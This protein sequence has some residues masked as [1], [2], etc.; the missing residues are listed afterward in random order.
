[1]DKSVQCPDDD[2]DGPLDKDQKKKIPKKLLS[3][4]VYFQNVLRSLKDLNDRDM[5]T[6]Q[7]CQ[8]I[9]T[10]YT[11]KHKADTQDDKQH[12]PRSTLQEFCYEYFLKTSGTK[13]QALK[14][15]FSLLRSVQ[16]QYQGNRRMTHFARFLSL[17]R[18]E[19]RPLDLTAL[20]YYLEAI[21][22]I[23]NH[24]IGSH[25]PDHDQ[26]SQECRYVSVSRVQDAV[27]KLLSHN[28]DTT[29]DPLTDIMNTL[30]QK[31]TTVRLTT[32]KLKSTEAVP[33]EDALELLLAERE[34][35]TS[36]LA[37]VAVQLFEAA[38]LNHDGVLTF[39]EFKEI[40]LKVDHTQK[41]RNISTL[42]RQA[43]AE[44][45]DDESGAMSPEQ[46]SR[47]LIDSGL[48]RPGKVP[49]F[50]KPQEKDRRH[51]SSLVPTTP[52]TPRD[53]APVQQ[54]AAISDTAT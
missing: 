12:K 25:I 3:M 32:G 52:R 47:I 45:E 7:V 44:N 49:D 28:M 31:I 19:L 41:E 21:D 54:L 23:S 46:F 11:E 40:L 26:P 51:R 14:T 38:D 5:P 27:K 33:L 1:M 15:L 36:S 20:N 2:E 24:K 29:R 18:E 16:K 34:R 37:K 4:P 42:F 35:E 9:D 50:L 48:I 8:L 13:P 53:Q 39:D 17:V 30:Q 22:T 43:M 6:P 10:I